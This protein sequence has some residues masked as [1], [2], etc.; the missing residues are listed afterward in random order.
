M[1]KE[2]VCLWHTIAHELAHAHQHAIAVRELGLS[3][4]TRDWEDTSEGQAYMAAWEKDIEEV[5]KSGDDGGY[6]LPLIENMA[7]TTRL[8]W[9]IEGKF[10]TPQ[11]FNIRNLKEETPIRLRWAQKWLN[12]K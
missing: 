12:K 5:G 3:A 4:I 11:C 8:F 10:N 9:N 6:F 7:N 2:G 1:I